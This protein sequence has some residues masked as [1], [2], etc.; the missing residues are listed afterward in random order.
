MNRRATATSDKG[1]HNRFSSVIGVWHF[2]VTWWYELTTP[3]SPGYSPGDGSAMDALRVFHANELRR[4]ARLAS[5]VL[6]FEMLLAAASLPIQLLTPN[7]KLI[8]ILSGVLLL[9]AIALLCNRFGR[10][11]VAGILCV[12]SINAGLLVVILTFP[13]IDAYNLNLFY[14]LVQ[15]EFAA[16]S[17]LPPRSVFVVAAFNIG[18]TTVG[19]FLLPTTVSLHEKLLHQTYSVLL[20][21]LTVHLLAAVVTYLWVRSSTN[22]SLRA[23]AAEASVQTLELLAGREEETALQQAEQIRRLT[24][25]LQGIDEALAAYQSQPSF[26]LPI[27]ES[28]EFRPMVYRLNHFLGR[29]S[30]Q[31]AH[32]IYLQRVHDEVLRYLADPEKWKPGGT[33]IDEIAF[34]MK[35]S[36]DP[37]DPR[38]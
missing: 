9:Q 26:R 6:F 28:G 25:L 17:L 35:S 7:K 8:F 27:T 5:N 36:V 4:R 30:R 14:L 21:P 37:P 1:L 24:S 31:S 33:L 10:I 34:Q 13:I 18:F 22:A 15:A 12:I 2:L 32:V 11:T 19:L 16:V 3:P 23:D 38:R 20:G 29:F